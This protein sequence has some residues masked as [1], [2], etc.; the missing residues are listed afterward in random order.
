[1]ALGIQ[2]FMGSHIYIVVGSLI[3]VILEKIMMSLE[4]NLLSPFINMLLGEKIL[5]KLKWQ[6]GK[7]EEDIIDLGKFFADGLKVIILLLITYNI[8]IYFEDYKSFSKKL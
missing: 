6:I 8:Y 5:N 3:Y 1:M 4:Q 2:N 7:N